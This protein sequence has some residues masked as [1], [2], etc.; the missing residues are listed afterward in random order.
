VHAQRIVDR[1]SDRI[2]LPSCRVGNLEVRLAA[3]AAEVR[4]AQALRYRVFYQEMRARPDARMRRAWRD[5]D[6]YDQRC[7]HLIVVDHAA[8]NAAIVGTYRL[9]D[10]G[11]AA[12]V[13]GFYASSEYDLSALLALREPGGRAPTLLELGRSCVAPAY[14]TSGAIMLLWRGIAAYLEAARIDYLFGCASF[15][16]TDPDAI[17][18]ELALLHHHHRAAIGVRARPE[19]HVPMD[20]IDRDAIDA[21]TAW[22]RLPPLVRGYLQAGASV[23]EGAFVDH[24]F[25][26]IDVF[27][28][29]A[30][31]SIRDRYR[32]RFEAR[33]QP[34]TPSSAFTSASAA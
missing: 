25:A 18:Q 10:A 14:R 5:A 17:G 11:A 32:N 23:G 26:T 3:S 30:T 16:G 31:A 33:R 20:R 9:I 29:V 19:L 21:G 28:I 24:Q 4:A 22:R 27:M 1:W 7:D 34:E 8:G 13:G 6:A 15:Q 2:V 12:A